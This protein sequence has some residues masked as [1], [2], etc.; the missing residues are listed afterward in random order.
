MREAFFGIGAGAR[1]PQM[2][3]PDGHRDLSRGY[4]FVFTATFPTFSVLGR[5]ECLFY[6]GVGGKHRLA[7]AL[8]STMFVRSLIF[9][10]NV[11]LLFVQCSLN[12]QFADSVPLHFKA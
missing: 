12:I 3:G 6:G 9:C 11:L 5:P 4:T 1:H 10:D 8:G 7:L 2:R